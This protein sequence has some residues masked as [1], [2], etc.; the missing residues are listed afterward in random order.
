MASKNSPNIPIIAHRSFAARFL[1]TPLGLVPWS[2][3]RRNLGG[4]GVTNLL[5]MAHW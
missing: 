2:A 4:A 3:Y 1:I 5:S